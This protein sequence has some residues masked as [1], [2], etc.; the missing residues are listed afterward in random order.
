MVSSCPP[1]TDEE[2]ASKCSV[3]TAIVFEKASKK[4]YK[5]KYCAKC[6]NVP[7]I[8]LTGCPIAERVAASS[9]FSTSDKAG[10]P[11]CNT[12]ELKAKFC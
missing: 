1:Y 2:T 9:L 5:N 8:T 3:E 6:N 12:P 7:E 4:A 10:S 11:P